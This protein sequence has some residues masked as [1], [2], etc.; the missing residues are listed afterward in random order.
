MKV[1]KATRLALQTRR[2]TIERNI[3]EYSDFLKLETVVEKQEGRG[4]YMVNGGNAY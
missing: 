2:T 4:P 1:E 3:R